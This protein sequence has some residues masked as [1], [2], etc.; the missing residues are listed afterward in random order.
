MG[1]RA[2]DALDA[3][4]DVVHP[5]EDADHRCLVPGGHHDSVGAFVDGV[6]SDELYQSVAH[7]GRSVPS[8]SMS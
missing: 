6:V 3:Q 2:L 4:S 1:S 8:S 7:R 5:L